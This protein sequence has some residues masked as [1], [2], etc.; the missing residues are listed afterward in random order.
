MTTRRRLWGWLAALAVAALVGPGDRAA[1]ADAEAAP[2]PATEA[3]WHTRIRVA[4][5]QRTPEI[6][7]SVAGRYAV[8]GP[9]T[10]ATVLEG[11]RL[12][13]T[14]V[15]ATRE[16]ILLG[17]E[18]LPL[19]AIRIEPARD[20]TIHV[21]GQRLRG[22]VE[23]RRDADQNLLVIN[24]IDLEDYLKGVLSKEAPHYWPMEALKALAI[25]ARTYALFQ[26][27]TKGDVEYDVSSDVLSQVYGGKTAEKDS[28]SRAVK[29]T[30]GQILTYQGR[31]FPTF[32]HSTCGGRT[33]H[34]SAMGP[35]DLEPLQGGVVCTFCEAS[36]FYRWQRRWTLA[37]VAWAV[38]KHGRGALS[39][40]R[41]VQVAQRTMMGR[42]AKVRIQG[43]KTLTLTGHEFRQLFG[44][45]ELRSTAFTILPW[46]DGIVV[47]GQGWGHGVGLCQWGTAELAR[48]ELSAEEIL[49]FYYPHANLVSLEE[50]TVE[51]IPI[52]KGVR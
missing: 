26:R 6:D 3:G 14:A 27:I 10:D 13:Q 23:I 52:P 1:A 32:Y 37:D 31:V 39:P 46:P 41:R 28:T 8:V 16:G 30:R 21:N 18:L 51:P 12:R 45:D 7:L 49:A 24:H 22:T 5:S 20:A 34:G 36:P 42:V 43:R 29:E 38:K 48:R 33:E 11:R 2:L 44:F 15:K 35:F 17:E 47:S 25:A 50:I 40:V 4:V 19:S 9:H